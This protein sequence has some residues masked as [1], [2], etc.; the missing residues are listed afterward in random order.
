MTEPGSPR[1]VRIS[2]GLGLLLVFL[3][4]IAWSLM[5]LGVRSLEDAKAFQILFYRSFGLI[6][7]LFLFMII[8]TRGH[9]FALI[10]S[11]GIPSILGGLVL[12]VAFTGSIVS[13]VTTSI[14]NAVFLLATAPLFS[15]ILGRIVL[16]E[17]VR[18]STI[19]TIIV[20]G[21]GVAVMVLDGISAGHWIGNA[22]AVMCAVCFA[23][24][25]IALRWERLSDNV[26]AVFYGGIFAVASSATA[27]YVAGQPLQISLHDVLIAVG[28]GFALGTGMILYTT[29]SSVVP[30]AESTLLSMSEVVL[31]PI[32]VFLLYGEGASRNTWIGGA[33]LLSALI[34]NALASLVRQRREVTR[35]SQGP[36]H[37]PSA[38]PQYGAPMVRH[39]LTPI[40]PQGIRAEPAYARR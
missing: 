40:R 32:W 12:V 21:V 30:A 7:C 11:A 27:A 28:L 35:Q 2:Y 25:T 19:V 33:I 34:G 8:R 17:R 13:L 26:P 6:T 37:S 3:A 29:G 5:G 18:L 16:G 10:G 1:A 4:G 20:G 22:A 36:R 9:P 15:A 39:T 24:F 38:L 23:I 14:A 31:S